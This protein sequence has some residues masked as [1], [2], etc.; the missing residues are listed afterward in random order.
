MGGRPNT[1]AD[2]GTAGG[3][4]AD[5][6]RTENGIRKAGQVF[7][8]EAGAVTPIAGGDFATERRRLCLIPCC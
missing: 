1:A 6:A 3:R 8:Y 4:P 2:K 7:N 5:Y